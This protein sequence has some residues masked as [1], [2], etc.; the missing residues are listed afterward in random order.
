MQEQV[1]HKRGTI[2]ADKNAFKTVNIIKITAETCIDIIKVKIDSNESLKKR[3]IKN[4]TIYLFQ[5]L[6]L[7]INNI[8]KFP[9]RILLL[10][11]LNFNL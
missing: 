6:M 11:C 1:C 7:T 3:T 10:I 2:A 4:C 8:C 9:N 5:M